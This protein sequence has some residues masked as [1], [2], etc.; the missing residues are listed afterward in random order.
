[1]FD[2]PVSY[3]RTSLEES[4]FDSCLCCGVNRF[5]RVS[6]VQVRNLLNY[7]LNETE[8]C[9]VMEALLQLNKIYRLLDKRQYGGLV[10]LMKVVHV[11]PAVKQRNLPF[12]WANVT[13]TKNPFFP[14]GDR[15]IFCIVLVL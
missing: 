13:L 4:F 3:L 10:S 2:S 11:I 5:G 14:F 1:M 8:T 12:V 9:P 15:I 6:F 7:M